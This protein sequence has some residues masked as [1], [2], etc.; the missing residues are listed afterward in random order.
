MIEGA[1]PSEALLLDM[2]LGRQPATIIYSNHLAERLNISADHASAQLQALFAAPDS[3]GGPTGA[4]R[5]RKSLHNEI[6]RRGWT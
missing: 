3:D 1:G 5:A 4:A 2:G 6:V